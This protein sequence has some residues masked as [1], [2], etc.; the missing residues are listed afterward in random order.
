MADIANMYRVLSV[1]VPHSHSVLQASS[2]VDTAINLNPT[3]RRYGGKFALGDEVFN[4]RL[5]K[6][7]LI[8]N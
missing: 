3:S 4:I 6:V 1:L 7:L 8:I 2:K 5:E